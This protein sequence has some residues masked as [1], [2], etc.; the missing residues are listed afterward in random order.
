MIPNVGS[1]MVTEPSFA[2]ACSTGPSF[3]VPDRGS[4]RRPG[5]G[6]RS[7]RSPRHA[8]T[9]GEAVAVIAVVVATAFVT[10]S[11]LHAGPI[12]PDEIGGLKLWLDAADADTFTFGTGTEVTQWRDK[13]GNSNDANAG[14]TKRPELNATLG[15]NSRPAVSFNRDQL[16]IAGLGIAE[17]TPRTAL[18]VMEY[19]TSTGSME[20]FGIGT[21]SMVDFGSTNGGQRLRL[22]YNSAGVDL[23]SAAGS[24]PLNTPH[25]I[26]VIGTT[27]LNQTFAENNGVNIITSTQTGFQYSLTG[28]V[29]VGG[30]FFSGREYVGNLAE[31]LVYDR[32]LGATELDWLG[33]YVQDKYGFEIEA[34]IVPEPS[35]LGGAVFALILLGGASRV[36]RK[37][38]R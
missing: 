15:P 28:N 1:F 34:A 26:T 11:Q 14:A 2:E 10:E 19:F 30:A 36:A 9:L 5:G 38:K 35:A 37:L 13:S 4:A 33:G 25:L 22:R 29:G 8:L 17:N 7:R 12:Q 32:A 27:G 18:L 31:V 23:Y 6:E 16:T 20:I 24:V 21:T 3:P